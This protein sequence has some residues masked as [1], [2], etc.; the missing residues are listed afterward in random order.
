MVHTDF[1]DIFLSKAVSAF[2]ADPR[3]GK[4]NIFAALSTSKR[5][6]LLFI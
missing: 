3:V 4:M 6:K 5:Q 1:G 2:E